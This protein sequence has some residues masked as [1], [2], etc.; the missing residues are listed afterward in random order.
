[1]ILGR[2]NQAVSLIFGWILF[3][4]I[5]IPQDKQV[6]RIHAIIDVQRRALGEINRNILFLHFLQYLLRN[7]KLGEDFIDGRFIPFVSAIGL[8]EIGRGIQHFYQLRQA[9]KFRLVI[10]LSVEMPILTLIAL[11][12]F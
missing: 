8:D 9:V 11:K 12:Q 7:H 10:K 3:G 4:W 1:M 6:Q 2:I 5:K